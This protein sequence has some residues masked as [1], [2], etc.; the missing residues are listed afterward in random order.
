[1]R[2]AL[3]IIFISFRGFSRKAFWG[4]EGVDLEKDGLTTAGCAG[5]KTDISALSLTQDNAQTDSI[6]TLSAI[7]PENA[8]AAS[9]AAIEINVVIKL[10]VALCRQAF[11]LLFG[12]EHCQNPHSIVCSSYTMQ[13]HFLKLI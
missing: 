1:M 3:A 4:Y 5:R 11:H 7:A 10:A 13:N 2:S 9:R 6:V 12:R 8:V